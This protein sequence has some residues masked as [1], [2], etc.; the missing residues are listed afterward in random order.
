VQAFSPSFTRQSSLKI[1]LRWTVGGCI[2][3]FLLLQVWRP[4]YFLTD[5][6]LSGCLPMFTEMGRHMKE[7]R[8]PTSS[9]YVFGGNYNYLRDLDAVFWHPFVLVPALLAD[10]ALRFWI[11][12]IPALLFLILTTVGFTLLACSLR[13]E[14]SLKIPDAYVVFY[15]LSFVFSTY[16]LT[17]GPSWLNFLGNQSSLPWLTLAILDRKMLRATLLV[18]LFTINELVVAYEP[19]TVTGGLC[20]TFFALGVA[21]WRGSFQPLF[22]W[23]A[24]NVLAILVLSPLLLAVL[25]G[26]AHS[27]RIGGL[28]YKD[29]SD[30]SVPASLFPFS[31]FLGNWSEPVTIWQ[32]DRTLATLVFP[33]LSSVLACAAAWCLIPAL[34]FPAKWRTLDKVCIVLIGIL[35]VYIVHPEAVSATIAQIPV[36][37]SMRWP[38]REGM[39]FLFFVHLFLV[40]RLP[41]RIPKWQSAVAVFSLMMFL[42]PMPFIR[43]PSLNPLVVD[44]QLLFSGEAERFWASVKLQLKPGDEI[45][46]VI[47]WPYFRKRNKGVPYTLLGTANFPMFFQVRSVSGYLPTTPRDQVPLKTVPEF[48]FGAYSKYQVNDVLAE[49]PDLKLLRIKDTHPLKITMSSGKEPPVDLTPYLHAAGFT[50]PATDPAFPSAR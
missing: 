31:F 6:N 46:T 22:C 4:C 32:G 50:D 27:I 7:G 34:F 33:Y 26:F 40:L 12:D 17:V 38:F 30:F 9:D 35:F 42:L 43:P 24:G 41:D 21:R 19:L 49:R 45:A 11:I 37:R 16:I 8:M 14:L 25:D 3:I 44:R 18:M 48:W 23:C 13:E 1:L 2:A 20:L 10:T 28:S 5:D 36:L 29:L 39:F 15:T 47:D